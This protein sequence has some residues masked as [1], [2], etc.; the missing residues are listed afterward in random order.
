MH[1]IKLYILCEFAD[2][3]CQSKLWE[4]RDYKFKV[5]MFYGDMYTKLAIRGLWEIRRKINYVKRSYPTQS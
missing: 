1:E 4:K 5:G 2:D 3:R